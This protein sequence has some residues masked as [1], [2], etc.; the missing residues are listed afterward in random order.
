MILIVFFGFFYTATLILSIGISYSSAGAINIPI[1]G[2]TLSLSGLATGSIT[3][4]LLNAVLP[5]KDYVFQDDKPNRT[6]VSFQI[7][8]GETIAESR[9]KLIKK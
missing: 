3:G 7:V 1:G 8:S 5:G 4:I 2:I 6:G 9:S